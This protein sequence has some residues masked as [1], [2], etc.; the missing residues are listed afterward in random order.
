MA[1]K[2]KILEVL[3]TQTEPIKLKRLGEL[4]GEPIGNFQTQVSRMEKESPP[5]V[6]QDDNKGYTI[7]EEGRKV[8]LAEPGAVRLPPSADRSEE[9][10]GL[11]PRAKFIEFAMQVGGTNQG[12]ILATADVVIAGDYTDLQWVANKLGEMDWPPDLKKRMLTRWATYLQS[13]GQK[14][15]V[16][17][18][19]RQVLH[20][21]SSGKVEGKD[22]KTLIGEHAFILDDKD[23]PQFL[24]AGI[25]N[26]D[27]KDAV[28]ISL[29]RASAM[30]R[31][32][33]GVANAPAS[34][35]TQA[36]DFVK[37]LNAIKAMQG[38]GK[39][40]V[41]KSYVIRTDANGDVIKDEQGN[42]L[43][44]ELDANK[45]I[46][47]ATSS[48]KLLSP[49]TSPVSQLQD[50]LDL[51]AKVR[52]I[53]G[54]GS[55]PDG[56]SRYIVINADGSTQEWKPGD[57]IP[58][59]TA[60]APAVAPVVQFKDPQGNP[61]TLDLSTYFRLDEHKAKM[62]REKESHDVKM[63]IGKQAKDFLAKGAKVLERRMG[64][65]SGEK[66]EENSGS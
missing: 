28:N 27:Y 10:L 21:D 3:A 34:L 65:R 48:S 6:L 64:G 50:A 63:D 54:F 20:I 40:P 33:S 12:V 36:E 30:A 58:F 4:L 39:A 14:F 29:M 18:E 46:I 31:A 5:L 35:G 1:V 56:Q 57:A 37:V 66:K 19:L 13:T 43:M 15:T 45:P 41:S 51:A 22:P 23:T 38:E 42:P 7:T 2:E 9:K 59:R 32:G 49:P 8:A 26:L 44:V 53:F 11:T 25:G 24:G 52:D 60:Q 16:P 17:E 55:K 62:D 61:M 47:L